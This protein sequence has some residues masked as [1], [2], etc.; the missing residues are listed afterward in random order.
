MTEKKIPDNS[1]EI[2]FAGG[3]FWGV[4]EYFSRIPGVFDAVSGYANGSIDN[5]AYEDVCTGA[6]GF[7]EAVRVV[8]DPEKVTLRTLTE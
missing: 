6:T 1:R 8:Y 3:C 4:E 2:Y 7:A 5:P